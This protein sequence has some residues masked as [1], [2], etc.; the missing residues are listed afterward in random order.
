MSNDLATG[1]IG[2]VKRLLD[3]LSASLVWRRLPALPPLGQRLFTRYSD[4]V[5]AVLYRLQWPLAPALLFNR[6]SNLWLSPLSYAW[7]DRKWTDRRRRSWPSWRQS[8]SEKD[9]D[10]KGLPVLEYFFEDDSDE[11]AVEQL[12]ST[13]SEAADDN[14][15]NL[16]RPRTLSARKAE[17]TRAEQL[18]KKIALRLESLTS[19]RS[20]TAWHRPFDANDMR[21]YPGLVTNDSLFDRRI[22]SSQH[23]DRL[24]ETFHPSSPLDLSPLTLNPMSEQYIAAEL[25]PVPGQSSSAKRALTQAVS[26]FVSSS[27]GMDSSFEP[28]GAPQV[29]PNGQPAN[30]ARIA[31]LSHL[32]DT[33]SMTSNNIPV[34]KAFSRLQT[35][36]GTPLVA[37]ST[38]LTEE[39]LADSPSHLSEPPQVTPGGVVAGKAGAIPVSLPEE[40]PVSR[41]DETPAMI[42]VDGR[43]FENLVHQPSLDQILGSRQQAAVHWLAGQIPLSLTEEAMSHEGGEPAEAIAS[44][45]MKS[46]S[47]G[48][49]NRNLG[50]GLA[51]API[52]RQR[53]NIPAVTSSTASPGQEGAL[54]TVGEATSPLDPEALASEVYDILKRRLAVEK[55]RTTLSVA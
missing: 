38:H 35:L 9:D 48:G 20:Y 10:I 7:F 21:Y 26:H 24:E 47:A 55:E 5:D 12:Q 29:A 54:E 36:F 37:S 2:R 6:S 8:G 14:T 44:S 31:S 50:V 51:L 43:Y 15:L 52:G 49:Y 17:F 25:M 34:G 53:E 30:E 22:F 40:P 33:A 19:K 42:S 23:L 27:E 32:F 11:V 41:R 1:I 45:T 28:S 16:P 3:G 13:E 4:W 46:S 39:A 18:A